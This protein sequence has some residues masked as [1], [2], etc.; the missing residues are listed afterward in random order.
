MTIL[1]VVAIVWFCAL[2]GLR[3]LGNPDEGR[4][5]EIPRE[6]AV[7]GDFVTP[8]LNGVK[9][10]EKPPLVYWLSALTFRAF[11]VNEFMARIWGGMFS[12]A[13]V[14][15]TYV[16]GRAIYGRSTGIWAAVI[17]ATTGYYYALSQIIL[18]DMAVSV[19]MAGCLLAFILA[20]REP[21]GKR[22]LGLFVCFYILM[23]LATLSKGLIGIAI[24]GAVIFL[25]VL[26][27]N[28]W[29]VLWPFH[30]LMGTLILLA[31]AGPWHVLAARANPDFLD[32]YFVHEHWLR[33]TTQI[34]ERDEPWW[35]FLPVFIAGLLPWTFF[36][37][38]AWNK[39]FS[40]GWKAR[41]DHS[42]A[43]FF[44]IWIVFI[45]AFFSKSQSKLVPYILPVFPAAAILLGRSLSALW[46]EQPSRGLKVS[47][48]SFLGAAALLVV[49][50]CVV[51][52]PKKQ[53]DLIA[54]LPALRKILGSFM[55]LGFSIA[56]LGLRRNQTRLILTAVL[57]AGSG[58]LLVTNIGS[59]FVDKTSTHKLALVLKPMLKA[60][61]RV[62][63]VGAYTQDLPV[64]LERLISVVDYRGELS[65]GI[66]AEPALTSSR[67]FARADFAAEWDRPGGAYAVV[68]KNTYDTWFTEAGIPHEVMART[69]RFIL[70]SKP[71]EPAGAQPKS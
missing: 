65:F 26:L 71:K 39:S 44:L 23:A 68:R 17:L 64:Y 40:G 12:V 66:D 1:L 55:L 13:G 32:F 7:T 69:D 14:L 25:W 2:L 46:N 36:F 18:L 28:R 43:W 58:F 41:R 22:R 51:P 38:L 29:R 16:A 67:F 31:I 49:A 57:L 61:D 21:R 3:P 20:M 45:I 37:P 5:T 59:R 52:N 50:A 9:Y 42:E 54:V 48:W 60:E 53:Q 11:G 47:T 6:M 56:M 35:F 19:T 10:F 70:I 15:F 34:H 62:Y 63:S 8:R 27:L 24:P 30:P 33:F 4:Y